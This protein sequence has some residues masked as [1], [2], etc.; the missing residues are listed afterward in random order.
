MGI[1]DLSEQGI[2]W[3]TRVDI[4]ANTTFCLLIMLERGPGLK[5]QNPDV[6]AA[7]AL[8]T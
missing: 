6:H 1:S 2:E 8:V 5:V 7:Y 3:A 4:I